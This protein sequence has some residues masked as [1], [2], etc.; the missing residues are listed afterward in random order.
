MNK[1]LD[2]RFNVAVNHI[3]GQLFPCGFDVIDDAPDTLE[4]LTDYIERTGRIAV[5]S[6]ASD[7]TVFSDPETNYAF[8]AWHDFHHWR[9]Q[10]SFDAYG[11]RVVLEHQVADIRTLYG[12]GADA[13]RM[14]EILEA[15]V[16]GQLMHEAEHGDFPEDQRAFAQAWLDGCWQ[17]GAPF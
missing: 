1:P 8:R 11:E 15:E 6:G 7:R 16:L 12:H 9:H 4:S 2:T 13:D 10:L 3:A 17:T 14:V 5:W